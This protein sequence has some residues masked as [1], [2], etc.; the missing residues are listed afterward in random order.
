MKKGL[1]YILITVVLLWSGASF[2]AQDITKYSAQLGLNDTIMTVVAKEEYGSLLTMGNLANASGGAGN[3]ATQY[4]PGVQ[5]E[6]IL[7]LKYKLYYLDY[8]EQQPQDNVYDETM[9]QAVTKYQAAKGMEQNIVIDQIL[10]DAL[11]GE[12]PEYVL[13][14]TGEEIKKYQLVLY[15]TDYLNVYPTGNFGDVTTTAVSQYQKNKGLPQS[16]KLDVATQE[17]LEQEDY[18][19]KIGKTGEEVAAMQRILITHGY[20]TGAASGTFDQNTKTAVEK[21]Q[22]E[23]NL[24]ITGE[25][26]KATRSLLEAL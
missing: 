4:A 23:K 11:N 18:A 24:P 5:N 25:M 19:Y 12:K 21:F 13:G 16:G 20:L 17:A 14:K 8:L 6:Q 7:I 3:M 2:A 1:L 22:T 26:D 15:F 9:Q 10:I